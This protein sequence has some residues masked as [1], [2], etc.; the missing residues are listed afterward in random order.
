MVPHSG[1]V[2]SSHEMLPKRHLHHRKNPSFSL[3]LRALFCRWGL[4][5]GLNFPAHPLITYASS[6]VNLKPYKIEQNCPK[7]HLADNIRIFFHIKANMCLKLSSEN[8]NKCLKTGP[9]TFTGNSGPHFAVSWGKS[10][11]ILVRKFAWILHPPWKARQRCT[12]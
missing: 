11:V 9:R 5:S 4:W 12:G 6:A 1:N 8:L 10:E 3:L 2:K 7:V